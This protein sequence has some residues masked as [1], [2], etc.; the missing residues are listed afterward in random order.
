MN[1]FILTPIRATKKYCGAYDI[2]CPKIFDYPNMRCRLFGRLKMD[3]GNPGR[4]LRHEHCI[5]NEIELVNSTNI[6]KGDK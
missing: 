5:Q 1:K 6:C 4:F 3:E 2:D